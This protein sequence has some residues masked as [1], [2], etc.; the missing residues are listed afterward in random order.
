MAAGT[1]DHETGTRDITQLSGLRRIMPLTFVAVLLA[2]LSM[3]GALPL[4]VG[5]IGKKLRGGGG[6]EV[7]S[8]LQAERTEVQQN[9]GMFGAILDMLDGDDDDADAGGDGGGGLLD[10]A[11]DLLQGQ[12]GRAILGALLGGR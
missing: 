9:D 8:S 5:Y 1:I 11:G 2:A 3:A 7:A 10:V 6:D 12:A 4:F